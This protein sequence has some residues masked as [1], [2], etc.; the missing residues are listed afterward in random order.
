MSVHVASHD[1]IG[2]QLNLN[3]GQLCPTSSENSACTKKAAIIEGV[4][5]S[6]IY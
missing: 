3:K 5:G 6:H 2:T 1:S 4:Y